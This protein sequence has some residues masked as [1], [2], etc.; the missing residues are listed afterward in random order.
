MVRLAP[1]EKIAL[2]KMLENIKWQ[3]FL[4][5]SRTD[6]KK[7]WWDIDIMIVQD[8][9]QDTLKQKLELLTKFQKISDQKVDIAIY[10]KKMSKLQKAFFN[11]INKVPIWITI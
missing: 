10:P 2:N 4:F 5:G 7:R 9:P 1:I 6:D 11:T 3:A 8:N